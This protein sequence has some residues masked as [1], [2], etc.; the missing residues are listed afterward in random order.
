M[1]VH[2]HNPS[3]SERKGNIQG[4]PE[5]H[6]ETVSLNNSLEEKEGKEGEK[7]RKHSNW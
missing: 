5:L 3:A 4:Q 6:G 7:E 1:V 2:K